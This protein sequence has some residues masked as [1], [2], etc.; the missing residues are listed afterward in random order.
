MKKIYILAGA[1]LL[2]VL[3]LMCWFFIFNYYDFATNIGKK[4]DEAALNEKSRF[5][6]TWET[7]FIPGDSRFIGTNGIFIFHLDG[8]GSIGG[9]QST[10]DIDEGQLIIYYNDGI[11]SITYDYSFSDDENTLIL[12]NYKGLLDFTRVIE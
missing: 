12:S 8:T 10:W 5:I 1:V 9:L 7:E 11:S 6:G 3:I 4:S 2:L